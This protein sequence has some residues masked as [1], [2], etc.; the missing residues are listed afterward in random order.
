MKGL[1]YLKA[2]KRLLQVTRLK[3][4]SADYR[5]VSPS[6]ALYETETDLANGAINT[7]E[8][9]A[10][11]ATRRCFE[12]ISGRRYAYISPKAVQLQAFSL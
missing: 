10:D 6:S 4:A 7:A 8:V 5:I 11:V 2:I 3:V 12:L 9:E 1:V